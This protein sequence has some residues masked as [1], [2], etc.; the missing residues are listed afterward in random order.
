MSHPLG[1]LAL[2]TAV[3]QMCNIALTKVEPAV[4]GVQTVPVVYYPRRGCRSLVQQVKNGPCKM[5]EIGNLFVAGAACWVEFAPAAGNQLVSLSPS[6]TICTRSISKASSVLRPIATNQCFDDDVLDRCRRAGVEQ[7]ADGAFHSIGLSGK[8]VVFTWGQDQSKPVPTGQTGTLPSNRSAHCSFS[9]L[10]L[11]DVVSVAAGEAHSICIRYDGTVFGFGSNAQGQLGIRFQ[12]D[13]APKMIGKGGYQPVP[14]SI[15]S[16]HRVRIASAACGSRFTLLVSEQGE[17]FGMGEG[18]CGQLGVGRVRQIDTPTRIALEPTLPSETL[19]AAAES[20]GPLD[21]EQLRDLCTAAADSV[22]TRV[23]SVAAGWA[24]TLILT[25]SGHVFATGFNA[26]G[27]LGM[28]D[29]QARYQ[30]ALVYELISLPTSGSTSP[31]PGEEDGRIPPQ[32]VTVRPFTAA[33]VAAGKMHS[34][35]LAPTGTVFTFG[36]AA[37]NRLGHSFDAAPASLTVQS[38]NQLEGGTVQYQLGEDGTGVDAPL[39]HHTLD[40]P[41]TMSDGL[42]EQAQVQQAPPVA[43]SY[44]NRWPFPQGTG[45]L[46]APARG[47]DVTRPFSHPPHVTRNLGRIL[48]KPAPAARDLRTGRPVFDDVHEN[49]WQLRLLRSFSHSAM[50]DEE[51][52]WGLQQAHVKARAQYD[53]VRDEEDL[54][55]QALDAL[56]AEVDPRSVHVPMGKPWLRTPVARVGCRPVTIPTPV[57]H[58]AFADRPVASV[59]CSR[60]ETLLFVREYPHV[61]V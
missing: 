4:I 54:R 27:Q 58:P 47:T 31:V 7:I 25:A 28:G 44:G 42:Q 59:A 3:E 33:R 1:T 20:A 34:A 46:K 48:G 56:E 30:P 49:T 38:V 51:K 35:L 23:V 18:G 14:R 36:S 52:E 32:G 55:M 37:D 61:Y 50:R 17:L 53:M 22:S 29:T 24:H 6:G 13:T 45:P 19:L 41:S 43:P 57:Q 15:S 10:R 2:V 8:G 26:S 21:G 11:E 60:A 40:Q 5:S 16:L 9:K 12:S 39:S